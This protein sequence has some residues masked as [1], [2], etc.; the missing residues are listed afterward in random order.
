VLQSGQKFACTRS[1]RFQTSPSVF[2][3]R[4]VEDWN[5]VGFAFDSKVC[6]LAALLTAF[7]FGL[8]DCQDTAEFKKNCKPEKYGKQFSPITDERS[9]IA[10]DRASVAD[11]TERGSILVP[12]TQIS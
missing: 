7:D 6:L 3:A 8:C 11:S 9:A 4:A 12:G 5:A 1:T 10:W 2:D